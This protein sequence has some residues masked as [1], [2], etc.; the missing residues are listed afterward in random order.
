MAKTVNYKGEE[1]TISEAMR[2]AGS[3]VGY[4]TV[5]RRLKQDWPVL[6]ALTLPTAHSKG[7]GRWARI[8][9]LD[10]GMG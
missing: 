8:R 1:I 10:G 3:P 5:L 6:R 9:P 4:E 2:R 7:D